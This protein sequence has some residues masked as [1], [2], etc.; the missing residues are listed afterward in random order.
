MEHLTP[1]DQAVL[2]GCTLFWGIPPEQLALL[3]GEVTQLD[4]G[5]FLVREGQPVTRIWVVLDGLLHT[6]CHNYSGQEFLYQQLRP[7]YLV[8]GEVV[9]TRRRTCPYS[10]YAKTSCRLWSFS[11][12]VVEERLIPPALCVQLM[13]NLLWFVSNQN[14]HKYSKLEALSEKSA[15]AK[16]M[17][18]LTG[19][20]RRSHSATFS[21]TMDRE[22]M[23]NYLCLN[24]SVLSHELKKME[25]EGLLTFHK[26]TF[27]L[28]GDSRPK[29]LR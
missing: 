24:R 10:I 5:A 9:C 4:E 3:D 11:W 27:T 23:A 26:N 21:V 20:A 25:A 13:Q 15:R 19:Q 17:K 12:R 22:A 29:E 18:Y 8:G 6:A 7:G 28:L 2:E 14:M 1:Q 16:I